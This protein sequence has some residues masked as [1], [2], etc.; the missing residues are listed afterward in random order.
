MLILS[1]YLSFLYYFWHN[2]NFLENSKTPT[3]NHILMP[4]I[5]RNFRK[6]SWT[7]LKKR[8]NVLIFAPESTHIL[9]FLY[10]DNFP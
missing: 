4:T 7:N 8:Q 9:H 1:T 6:I 10:N 5:Q 3:L 2:K